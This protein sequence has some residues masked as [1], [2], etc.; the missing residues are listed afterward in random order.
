MRLSEVSIELALALALYSSKLEIPLAKDV[1]AFGELSLA[2]EVRPVPFHERRI[3][4]LV[5]LGY[6]R[7]IVSEKSP[8]LKIDEIA[9]NN[10]KTALIAAFGRKNK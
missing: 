7:A 10:I 8:G 5:S 2:G 6:K 4:S 1:A 3:K 9:V